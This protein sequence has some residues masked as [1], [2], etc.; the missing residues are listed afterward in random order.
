MDI[1]ETPNETNKT[2]I[3]DLSGLRCLIIDDNRINRMILFN[4]LQK[5]G[6]HIDNVGSGR[7]AIAKAT[8]VDYDI[9]FMDVHMPDMDGFETTRKLLEINQ[10]STVI[11]VSADVTLEAI[12]K[13]KASGMKDY[14]TKPIEKEVLFETLGKLAV[15]SSS[16]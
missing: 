13:A 16:G 1:V 11:G 8:N 9:V 6:V 12:E 3:P 4:F 7:Q 5:T 2:E 10:E 14:L 15:T